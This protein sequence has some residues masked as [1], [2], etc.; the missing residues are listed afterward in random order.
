MLLVVAV[1]GG[2]IGSAL[3]L[4]RV[5]VSEYQRDVVITGPE[6]VAVP[7]RMEFSVDEPLPGTTHPDMTVGVA[8]TSVALPRP[9]C[10]VST[11]AGETVAL[12]SPE[13]A[14]T[15]YRDDGDRFTVVASARLSPGD[16]VVECRVP[17]EPSQNRSAGVFTVG[18]T[19]GPDEFGSLFGPFL[20]FFGILGLAGFLFVLGVVLL[21]VGLVLRSRSRRPPA[22]PGGLPGPWGQPVPWGPPQAP[23]GQPVPPGPPQAPWGQQPGGPPG[24]PPVPSA[25][26]PRGPD[27]GWPTP[28]G[29]R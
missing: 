1:L 27:S 11:A 28:P 26:P 12:S 17:G 7:G 6:S 10:V 18:R 9:D 8:S 14:S 21:I 13:F 24:P 23:W 3:T 15:L 19:F 4:G 29:Q 25:P 22:L 5:D 20:W 16:Y 2:F